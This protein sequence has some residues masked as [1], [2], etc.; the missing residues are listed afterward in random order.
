MNLEAVIGGE[1]FIPIWI[2]CSSSEPVLDNNLFFFF[3]RVR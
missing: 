2:S 1:I 3:K